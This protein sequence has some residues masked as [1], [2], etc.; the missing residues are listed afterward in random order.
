MYKVDLNKIKNIYFLGIGGIGMSALARYFN[1]MNY[2]VSG[3]DL[4]PSDLTH[5]LEDEGII[6]NYKD[7]IAQ[8]PSSISLNDSLIV[9]TPAIPKDN[10]QL[11]YLKNCG[12]H[13]LK[14]SEILGLISN[15]KKAL[16]V[17]GTH[18]KTTITTML[19]YILKN[20]SIG[21]NAFLGGL[22]INFKS[23]LLIDKKSEYVV[24]EADE[25]DR[26]FLNLKPEIAAISAMD[27]DHL[28]IYGDKEHMLEA[29]NEFVLKTRSGGK[30]FLKSGL[31]MSGVQIDGYY[32]ILGVNPPSDYYSYN[33]RMENN[34]YMFDYHS[35]KYEIKNI[36]LGVPGRVNVENATLAITI[37]LEVG[38]NPDE[39]IKSLPLFKGV[40]RRFNIHYQGKGRIFIDD[41]AHHPKEISATLKSVREIWKDKE[42]TVIFQPHLYTRTRDF[43]KDF[44]RSLSIADK[45]ILL[46]IYPARESPIRGITSQIIKDNVKVPVVIVSKEKLI[47]YLKD[48]FNSGIL[49]TMGAGNID[50]EVSNI[51]DFLVNLD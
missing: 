19:A 33:L 8:I 20:S 47:F 40:W 18:G 22:S 25:F 46:D 48:N 38:V 30:V 29:F 32:G 4:T 34:S 5:K 17:A 44:A 1:E 42:L 36:E 10:K 13:I 35:P 41:Y 7:E 27:A 31:S 45:V 23:N 2:K 37:A 12:F 39:I 26:S 24:V 50:R 15:E 6:V 3:Y 11:L 21:C 49:M 51:K 14:R 16:C 9:F 28:D 43:Y